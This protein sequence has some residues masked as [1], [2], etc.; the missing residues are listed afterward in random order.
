MP[1]PIRRSIA[2]LALIAWLVAAC[3]SS[4]PSP[5]PTGP[6]VAAPSPVASSVP[7]PASEPPSAPSTPAPTPAPTTAPPTAPPPTPVGSSVDAAPCKPGGI[8]LDVKGEGEGDAVVLIIDVKNTSGAPCVLA[9]PPSSIALRAG[10]GSLPLTYE[11]LAWLPTSP[12]VVAP[13][14]LLQ[15]NW[16]ARARAIWRNWCLGPAEVSTVWVGF[17]PEAL[18][19]SPDPYLDP[20]PCGNQDA[21]STIQGF[22]FEEDTSGG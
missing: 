14:V 17:N 12:D 18:D 20:P 21:E 22:P 9:G 10:G 1:V 19:T 16:K 4:I 3:G 7:S 11:A 6:D 15:P 8:K 2:S 13:P 5:A